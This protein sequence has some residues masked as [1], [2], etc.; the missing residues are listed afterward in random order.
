MELS[1]R[2]SHF[3]QIK[4]KNYS[5]DNTNGNDSQPVFT[6]SGAERSGEKELQVR[7]STGYDTSCDC[8]ETDYLARVDW[9]LITDEWVEAFVQITYAEE[10]QFEMTLTRMSDGETIISLQDDNIDT[11][12]G[13][14]AADFVRPKWGIYRSI[15]DDVIDSLRADEERVHFADFT[16]RKGTLQ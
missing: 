9:D 2:F 12:R 13:F 3:F 15:A 6:L 14:E 5:E 4:A 10:G 16:I 11:W 8:T 7:H 1:T